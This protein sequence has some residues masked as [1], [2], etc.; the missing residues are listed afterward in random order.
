MFTYIAKETAKRGIRSLILAH[1]TELLDQISGTLERAGVDHGFIAAGR[2]VKLPPMVQVG[3]VATVANR[4]DQINAP[5]VIILDEAHHA[6]AG[7]WR[8][9]LD[10]YPD[11]KVLGVTATPQRLDGKGLGDSFDILIRGPEVAD[12]ITDGYLTKPVYYAPPNAIISAKWRTTA[13]DWNKADM[14]KDVKAITGDLVQTW[15]KYALNVP[16]IAFCISVNHAELLADAFVKMGIPAATLHGSLSPAVRTERVN[17]LASGSLTV[18]TTCDLVSEGFDLP[19]VGC[20]I[21]ARPTQSLGLWLQQ[22]GRLLRLSPGKTEAIVLDHVGN[23]RRHGFAEEVREWSLDGKKRK[24]K[25]EDE[26]VVAV[27]TC[28]QCFAVFPPAPVC[29]Q[30]CAAIEGKKREIKTQDGELQ[31][32]TQE[33][34]E[35]QKELRKSE[36]KACRDLESLIAL[37]KKRNYKNP[38]FWARKIM[39]SR[40]AWKKRNGWGRN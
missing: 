39:E 35:R 17:A 18:L 36:L 19:A 3:G 29:P 38:V 1:R 30:C 37:G 7:S 16:T 25:S 12:L 20:G 6:V 11:A 8:K 27:A 14:E 22:L 31:K 32:L 24:K 13:G 23:T 10:R 40:D 21:M 28:P 34:I 33:D 15:Q 9:I 5:G 26:E 4:L 2:P